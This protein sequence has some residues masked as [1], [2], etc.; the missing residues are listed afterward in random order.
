VTKTV[1]SDE[2]IRNQKSE[3]R[4]QKP[5]S[6]KHRPSLVHRFCFLVS[7]FWAAF[8]RLSVYR[9]SVLCLALFCMCFV[10]GC[11]L[12]MHIDPRYD[13]LS[14]SSFFP[15]GRSERPMVPGTVARG[16]LRVD[17]LLYTGK[18]NGKLA[19]VFPFP[20]TRKDL[21]R[22]QERFNIYCTPCH[23]Y[24]GSGTGMVVRRGFPA[25]P[26]YHIPRLMNAPVGHFF[27]V[28]TNGYGTMFSYAYRVSVEDRWRVAAYIRVL[29]L[30]ENGNLN[31]VPA[32]ERLKLLSDKTQ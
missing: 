25:P 26:S 4:N 7:D 23:D 13:P 5:E 17:E 15:D 1:M 9:W 27:D 32:A 31:E 3:I 8:S 12:D 16:H 22:G 10:E 14:P 21:E 28:M 20:I 18:I 11:R 6:G 29:Q 19:N 2:L 24:T 30:S